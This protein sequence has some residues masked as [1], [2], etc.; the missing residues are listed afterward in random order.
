MQMHRTQDCFSLPNSQQ[1]YWVMQ[2]DQAPQPYPDFYHKRL[3]H[4]YSNVFGDSTLPIPE[5]RKDIPS[6]KKLILTRL[7]SGRS[8]IAEHYSDKSGKSENEG[9][10]HRNYTLNPS[11]SGAASGGAAS[12]DEVSSEE[13]DD[14]NQDLFATK[15]QRLNQTNAEDYSMVEDYA[16]DMPENAQNSGIHSSAGA[17]SITTKITDDSE[18][19]KQRR[20]RQMNRE[21]AKRSRFHKQQDCEKLKARIEAL[22]TD[23]SALHKELDSLSE[24]CIRIDYENEQ[25]KKEVVQMC[26]LGIINDL[27]DW[28]PQLCDGET[29]VMQE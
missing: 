26:G 7:F 6:Q 13:S 11:R 20:R 16:A 12:G 18:L 15:K 2:S 14:T 8:E 24:E 17:E 22:K 27:K 19:R 3:T 10:S 9:T 28:R 23:N 5:K 4:A 25:I 1:S 29:E 21:S